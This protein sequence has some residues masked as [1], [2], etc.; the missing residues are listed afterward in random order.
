VSYPRVEDIWDTENCP[1]CGRR[2]LMRRGP[3]E[4]DEYRWDC[5][6]CNGWWSQIELKRRSG[7]GRLRLPE[8]TQ[9]D[10]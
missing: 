5:S 4:N 1:R 10:D 2:G 8:E 6:G 7:G 9:S 3:Y